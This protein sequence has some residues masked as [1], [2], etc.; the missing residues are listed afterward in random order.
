[1]ASFAYLR[2]LDGKTA[3]DKPGDAASPPPDPAPSPATAGQAAPPNSQEGEG[4]RQF[5]Y[6]HRL[7]R[8][9]KS[10]GR[11]FRAIGVV[12][13]DVYD[14]LI[15]LQELRPTFPDALFFTTDLDARLLQPA[16]YALTTR[17]LIIVSHYGLTLPDGLQR[18]IAPFRSGYDT[19]TYLACLRAVGYEQLNENNR[20]Y[21]FVDVKKWCELQHLCRYDANH[22]ANVLVPKV[23]P[24][25]ELAA[26]V[27]PRF[28]GQSRRGVR[29]D[30]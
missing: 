18:E 7:A 3:A 8:E 16:E 17:N 9:M 1:M 6:V 13:S 30:Q 12:G 28:R 2:G 26:G 19:A 11:R 25:A 24:G 23:L 4:Q 20:N 10:S 14:K 22:E 29:T 5:D 21:N 15:L 27:G